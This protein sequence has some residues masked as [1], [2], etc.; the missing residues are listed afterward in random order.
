MGTPPRGGDA[1]LAGRSLPGRSGAARGT[2]TAGR[3]AG[4]PGAVRLGRG[5]RRPDPPGA[6]TFQTSCPVQ[7]L[8]GPRRDGRGVPGQR[9]AAGPA[10]RRE[11]VRPVRRRAVP[12]GSGDHEPPRSPGRGAGL[13]PGNGRRGPP[14]LR[15]AVRGRR[16]APGRDRRTSFQRRR[17]LARAARPVH[18]RVQHHRVRAQPRHPAPRLEARERP[19]RAVRG[20]PR[21]RLGAGPVRRPAGRRAVGPTA[22]RGVADRHGDV[23][24]HGRVR[25]AGATGGPRKS[26]RRRTYSRSVPCYTTC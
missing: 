8:P 24:G 19:A 9:P 3:R 6:F 23:R 13:R 10:G 2:G 16:H 18:G 21:R 15:H 4:G 14:L 25:R 17:R 26:G 12:E 1:G 11:A 22:D 5:R 7:A 20:D